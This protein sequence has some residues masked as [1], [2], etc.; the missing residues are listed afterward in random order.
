MYKFLQQVFLKCLPWSILVPT[1]AVVTLCKTSFWHTVTII[2]LG[3]A[4]AAITE[5]IVE[6]RKQS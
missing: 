1:A 5:V 4:G 2:M 6:H 3:A